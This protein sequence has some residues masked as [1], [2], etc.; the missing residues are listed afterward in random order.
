MINK[1][2]SKEATGFVPSPYPRLVTYCVFGP[3]DFHLASTW[4]RRYRLFSLPRPWPL[5]GLWL[6]DELK[7]PAP[8]ELGLFLFLLAL[9][10][11]GFLTRHLREGGE[12]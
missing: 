5:W 9:T 7:P 8:P 10:S 1:G 12:A 11:G 4:M 3:R 6:P 2:I